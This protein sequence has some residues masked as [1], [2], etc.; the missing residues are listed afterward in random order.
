M[1]TLEMFYLPVDEML[2]LLHCDVLRKLFMHVELIE[3]VASKSLHD[4]YYLH[5]LSLKEFRVL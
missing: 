4:L 3:R 2:F 5:N 1:V